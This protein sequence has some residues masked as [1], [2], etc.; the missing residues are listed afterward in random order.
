ASG[1]LVGLVAHAGFHA[2]GGQGATRALDALGSRNAGI[3]KRQLDV[4]QSG[5]AGQQVEGLK[6]KPDFLISDSRQLVVVELADLLPVEPVLSL[7]GR[8]EAADQ[9]HQR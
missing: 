7:A 6:D 5:C 4:V 8:V 1:E 9:V 2:D 3:N